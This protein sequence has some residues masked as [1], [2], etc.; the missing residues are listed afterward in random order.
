MVWG[1]GMRI[2]GDERVVYEDVDVL[3]VL[4]KIPQES[5]DFLDFADIQL[6]R[7]YLDAL[8]EPLDLFRYLL[9]R[10]FAARRQDQ[11]QIVRLR[12]REFNRRGL[13]DA[14]RRAGNHNCLALEALRHARG[15]SGEDSGEL[16]IAGEGEG[17]G[18][19]GNVFE[20]AQKMHVPGSK[21][22]WREQVR[23]VRSREDVLWSR[24]VGLSPRYARESWRG[25]GGVSTIV[26][27]GVV[28]FGM[29]GA[30]FSSSLRE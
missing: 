25:D 22:N 7:Q 8:R 27:G 4:G 16:G 3:E 21:V 30:D 11:F 2:G 13:P 23:E 19:I 24:G 5:L 12:A 18:C 14:R 6:H 26:W 9:K 15:H 10:I 17:A 20:W 29:C 28:S 1:M